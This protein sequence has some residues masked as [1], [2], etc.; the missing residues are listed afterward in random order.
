MSLIARKPYTHTLG[1]I[2]ADTL[3]ACRDMMN[4]KTFDQQCKGHFYYF[5]SM[6]SF[7]GLHWDEVEVVTDSHH[8]LN[9]RLNTVPEKICTN[10]LW[11]SSDWDEVVDFHHRSF[12]LLWT[13]SSPSVHWN[14]DEV[15]VVIDWTLLLRKICTNPLWSS[16]DWREMR[17]LRSWDMKVHSTY[18]PQPFVSSFSWAICA[19]MWICVYLCLYTFCMSIDTHTHPFTF[20]TR[21]TTKG[22]Q[23]SN[24]WLS[25]MRIYKMDRN[26][27]QNHYSQ[28]SC[29][30]R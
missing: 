26:Y 21:I 5:G 30:N 16:F 6:I 8:H 25:N 4:C 15:V 2:K 23:K 13:A 28:G 18:F 10:P 14:G 24:K 27:N 22:S 20:T 1:F 11:F 19:N 9:T 29:K 17:A 3:V 7:I 12:L